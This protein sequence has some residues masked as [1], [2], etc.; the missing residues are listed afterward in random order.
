MKKGADDLHKYREAQDK[1]SVCRHRIM[2]LHNK[3]NREPEDDA[4]E[5]ATDR[6]DISRFSWITGKSEYSKI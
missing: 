2:V 3:C 5:D 4:N 1:Q 6:I